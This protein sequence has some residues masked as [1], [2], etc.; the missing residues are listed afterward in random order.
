MLTHFLQIVL[1][2]QLRSV[3]CI[4]DLKHLE[5][6]TVLQMGIIVI[7]RMGIYDDPTIGRLPE[8]CVK[9]CRWHLLTPNHLSQHI[10][11][12]NRGELI[13]VTDNQQLSPRLDTFQQDIRQ[14]H[15]YH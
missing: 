3:L 1:D 9:N 11:C 5:V 13:S 8:D 12:A 10:S 4:L 2:Y 6:V 14:P 15:I 7:D